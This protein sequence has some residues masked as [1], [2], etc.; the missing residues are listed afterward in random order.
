[1]ANL[2]EVVS[3]KYNSY[4]FHVTVDAVNDLDEVKLNGALTRKLNGSIKAMD[5]MMPVGLNLICDGE[6]NKVRLVLL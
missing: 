4:S 3:K 6:D 2:D 5:I 1:M